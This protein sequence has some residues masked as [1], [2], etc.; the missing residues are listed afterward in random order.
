MDR[1]DSDKFT[2]FNWRTWSIDMCHVSILTCFR[3]GVGKDNADTSHTLTCC[4][5]KLRS[6]IEAG[7]SMATV[8]IGHVKLK[9]ERDVKGGCLEVSWPCNGNL[10]K[11]SPITHLNRTEVCELPHNFCQIPNR[12]LTIHAIRCTKCRKE[13][14]GMLEW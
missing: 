2:G 12:H 9:D 11:M 5:S 4:L 14:L 10:M 8:C 13:R 3:H 7:L 6:S 1:Y